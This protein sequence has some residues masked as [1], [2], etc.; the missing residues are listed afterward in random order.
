LHG[1]CTTL[2]LFPLFCTWAIVTQHQLPLGNVYGTNNPDTE[3]TGW[4]RNLK[5][6]DS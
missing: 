4:T 6:S 2:N 3:M 1:T 5:I